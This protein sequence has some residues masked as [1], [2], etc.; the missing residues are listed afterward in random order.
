MLKIILCNLGVVGSATYS[1]S[2]FAIQVSN[3]MTSVYSIFQ[4]LI[5]PN[6]MMIYRIHHLSIHFQGYFSSLRAELF[7]KGITVTAICPGPIRTASVQN[8]V[9]EVSGE[10]C[11]TVWYINSNGLTYARDSIKYKHTTNYP[12]E[13][14]ESSIGTYYIHWGSGSGFLSVGQENGWS[15]A[16]VGHFSRYCFVSFNHI[17]KIWRRLTIY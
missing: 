7:D 8:A 12:Q 15:G 4:G 2:K 10:V 6:V 14:C 16:V 5:T 1:A 17:S 13:L 3:Y 11:C 9:T